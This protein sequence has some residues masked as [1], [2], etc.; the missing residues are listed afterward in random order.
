MSHYGR[1]GVISRI[2]SIHDE[3]VSVF[4]RR[5]ERMWSSKRGT[6]IHRERRGAARFDVLLGCTQ[7][8]IKSRL[9]LSKILGYYM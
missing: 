2:R 4:L 9:V 6:D 7:G 5:R 8:H 3:L 1:T